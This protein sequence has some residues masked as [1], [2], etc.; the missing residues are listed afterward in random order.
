MRYHLAEQLGDNLKGYANVAILRELTAG[1]SEYLVSSDPCSKIE[2]NLTLSLLVWG[3]EKAGERQGA[4][5][6]GG[7]GEQETIIRQQSKVF[8]RLVPCL[9]V[10]IEIISKHGKLNK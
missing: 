6:R 1:G 7:C 5:G 3:Q 4:R 10:D 2:N 9:C 8:I